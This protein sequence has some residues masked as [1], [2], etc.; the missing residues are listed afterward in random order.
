MKAL[1]FFLFLLM[2]L[3]PCLSARAVEIYQTQPCI[4][5]G[6]WTVGQSSGSGNTVATTFLLGDCGIHTINLPPTQS[7]FYRTI[8]DNNLFRP[9]GWTPPARSNPIAYSAPSC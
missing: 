1:R 8:V 7:D 3:F 5:W 9:L 2:V 6:N 4:H